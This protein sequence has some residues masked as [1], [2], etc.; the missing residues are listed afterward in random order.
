M[1][2]ESIEMAK[3]EKATAA[4]R[5]FPFALKAEAVHTVLYQ[6]ALDNLDRLTGWQHIYYACPDCGNTLTGLSIL[7]YLICGHR[8][9]GFIAVSRS[10]A[11]E[12]RNVDWRITHLTTLVP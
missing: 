12:R 1:Y 5:S 2:A 10:G 11:G 4:I 9:A 3:R 8:N 7:K 6:D